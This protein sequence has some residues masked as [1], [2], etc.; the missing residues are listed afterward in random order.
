MLV[1]LAWTGPPAPAHKL[2]L[3]G[4]T[5]IL[6]CPIEPKK[7]FGPIPRKAAE[8]IGGLLASESQSYRMTDTQVYSVYGGSNFF[9]PDFNKLPYLLRWQGDNSFLF[10][11]NH[12][13]DVNPGPCL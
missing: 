13:R 7:N 11:I 9:A 5:V 10:R 1:P 8:I 12:Y 4:T 3:A 6:F 2:T